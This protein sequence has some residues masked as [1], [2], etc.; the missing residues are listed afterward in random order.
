MKPAARVK[1]KCRNAC[2][3]QYFQFSMTRTNAA[4]W[5]LSIPAAL[6]NRYILGLEFYIRTVQLKYICII[7]ETAKKSPVDF[8]IGLAVRQSNS[9]PCWQVTNICINFC[10]Q[11]K[12]CAYPRVIHFLRKNACW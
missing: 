9:N 10:K 2:K 3:T 4:Y 1:C 6:I 11:R 7:E 5:M 12:D 8:T